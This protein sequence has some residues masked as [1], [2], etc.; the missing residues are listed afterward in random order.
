MPSTSWFRVRRIAQP[1]FFIEIRVRKAWHNVH[2]TTIDYRLHISIPKGVHIM[3]STPYLI[4]CMNEAMVNTKPV[5]LEKKG[6]R[7]H[8]ITNA[9]Y[10]LHTCGAYLIRCFSLGFRC[11]RDDRNAE[12]NNRLSL[13]Y[14]D[15]KKVYITYLASIFDHVRKRAVINMK[16]ISLKKI[17]EDAPPYHHY[18]CLWAAH[19]FGAY[20]YHCFSLR[21]R[22]V[23]RNIY[24]QHNNKL[25]LAY[26]NPEKDVV[27]HNV[28][29]FHIRSCDWTNWTKTVVKC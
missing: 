8:A 2:N 27:L 10:E 24:T 23:R 3:Y 1:L 21:F 11:A 4:T 18:C 28:P 9:V 16:P 19:T 6:A 12:H 14:F 29:N 20:L 7:H 17:M 25:P 22:C 26:F 13:P 5:S 15:P